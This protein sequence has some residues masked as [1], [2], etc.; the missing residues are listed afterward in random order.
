MEIKMLKAEEG[1]C[2]IIKI[3]DTSD[4]DKIYN[5]LIDGGVEDTFFDSLES[6]VTD[7]LKRGE[8]IDL[9]IITHICSDHLD[10]IKTM[11]EELDEDTL[12]NKIK[13]VWFNS[14]ELIADYLGENKGEI[15]NRAIKI[16]KKD[17]LKVSKRTGYTLEKYLKKLG[18]ELEIINNEIET[19][20]LD[21]EKKIKFTILSPNKE[22]L[23]RLNGVWPKEN[24]KIGGKIDEDYLKS[25]EELIA[26]DSEYLD[27]ANNL[28]KKYKDTSE[29]NGASIAFLL[30]HN[31]KKFLFL[32][33]SYED[34]VVN[35]I[36]DKFSN[37]LPIE[38]EVMKV[39]HHGSKANISPALLGLIDCDKFMISTDGESYGHP[40]KRCF[41][42][43]IG[44]S[45]KPVT[46]YFNYDLENKIFIKQFQEEKE[47]YKYN[48]LYLEEELR[49]DD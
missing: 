46:F 29:H 9:L 38:V 45:K 21:K 25:I 48:C 31:D 20:Y 32:G 44:N 33:D 41:A 1:D 10:G 30:E 5:I 13:K 7:I 12:K 15:E 28:K 3:K 37:E 24:L 34:I 2:F 43:I 19:K 39:S 40:N 22:S 42:R 6:E 23:E 26:D 18:I 35:S 47:K 17:S 16:S 49:I 27:E 11:F 4:E 14:A 36:K 8:N